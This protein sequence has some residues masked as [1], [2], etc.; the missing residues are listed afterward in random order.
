MRVSI[1]NVPFWSGGK[2]G[3]RTRA[4]REETSEREALHR[5]AMGVRREMKLRGEAVGGEEGEG[6]GG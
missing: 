2:K 6:Q 3:W 4:A 5:P 1:L